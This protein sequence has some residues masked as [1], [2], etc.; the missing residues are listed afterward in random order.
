MLKKN[1]L[2]FLGGDGSN[3]GWELLLERFF[4]EDFRDLLIDSKISALSKILFLS[5][6]FLFDWNKLSWPKL[7]Y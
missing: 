3:P 2:L 5:K 6:P 4:D 7:L 1:F